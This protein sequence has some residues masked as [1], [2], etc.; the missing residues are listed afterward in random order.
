MAGVP[1][2]WLLHPAQP[3]A[4]E[5]MITP[6][7]HTQEHNDNMKALLTELV[8]H[9]KEGTMVQVLLLACKIGLQARAPFEERI[10][11][12]EDMIVEMNERD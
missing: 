12:L 5:E 11:E 8:S 7:V 2:P 3:N 1:A 4:G 6:V 10:D 9:C